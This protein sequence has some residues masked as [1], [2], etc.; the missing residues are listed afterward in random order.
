MCLF[1]PFSKVLKCLLNLLVWF[2]QYWFRW[3]EYNSRHSF[4]CKIKWWS[5]FIIH[6]VDYEDDTKL[7][8]TVF[9]IHIVDY[10]NDTKLNKTVFFIHIVKYMKMTLKHY[11]STSQHINPILSHFPTLQLYWASFP[12]RQPYFISLSNPPTLLN[13]LCNSSTLFYLTFQPSNSTKPA[14][15]LTNPIFSHFP[16]LQLYLISFQPFNPTLN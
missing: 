8:K 2:C 4:F 13:Q 11:Y 5:L 12:T 3:I 16:T 10:E 6:I 14:S 7:N 15:Q 9:F 1:S